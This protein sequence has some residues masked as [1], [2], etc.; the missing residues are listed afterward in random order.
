MSGYARFQAARVSEDRAGHSLSPN[1]EVMFAIATPQAVR[2]KRAI[3][4]AL[5]VVLAPL[6]LILI[7]PICVLVLLESGSPV[8]RHV[9]VGRGG[10]IFHCYKIR[11]MAAD[12]DAQLKALLERNQL[13]RA[14][15]AEQFKLKADPRVTHLGRFLR[16]ASLDEL[17]QLWNVLKGEMSFIGPRPIIPE[18]LQLY[19]EHAAAYLACSPGISGLWQVSGRNDISYEERV[20]LDERYARHWTLMLDLAILLRTVPVVLKARG[21][22]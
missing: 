11:T 3:D 15:W 7:L 2:V 10:R 22:Y 5:A 1:N 17:P 8:Y 9:R 4:L 14:E 13:A 20:L 16:K 19:G 6:V 18:E 12:A 21:S